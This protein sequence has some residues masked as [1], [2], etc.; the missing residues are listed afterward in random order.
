MSAC[1]R[2]CLR[3]HSAACWQDQA[4]A[5]ES[6]RAVL[7][8]ENARMRLAGGSAIP[9]L[10]TQDGECVDCE[11]ELGSNAACGVCVFV[12]ILWNR[13]L[14]AAP[15]ASAAG[16]SGDAEAIVK[17][18]SDSLMYGEPVDP[19]SL[20]DEQLADAMLGEIEE[21]KAQELR[22]HTRLLRPHLKRPPMHGY[23]ALLGETRL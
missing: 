7:V 12:A 16:S 19:A 9:W 5:A 18:W 15:P 10:T 1:K 4:E 21:K 20:T 14:L 23:A 22:D 17:E 6:A 3:D 13:A 2:S 8:A 11:K